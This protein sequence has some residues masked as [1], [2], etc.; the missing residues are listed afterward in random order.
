MLE[1]PAPPD[2]AGLLDAL[3]EDAKAASTPRDARRA[4]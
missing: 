4:R 2:L 3:R 1:S